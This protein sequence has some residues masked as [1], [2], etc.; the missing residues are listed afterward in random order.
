MTD[1][2]G[3]AWSNPKGEGPDFFVFE[4]GGN[5]DMF[6]SA[7]LADG[8]PGKPIRFDRSAWRALDYSVSFAIGKICGIAISVTDLPDAEGKALTR[9]AVLEGIRL[10]GT[11]MDPVSVCAVKPDSL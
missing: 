4:A 6:I 1:F 2:G 7:L 10:T 9:D 11:G 3:G 5:D 8:K